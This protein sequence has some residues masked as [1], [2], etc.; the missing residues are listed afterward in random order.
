MTVKQ[1]IQKNHAEAERQDIKD[2]NAAE[3]FFFGNKAHPAEHHSNRYKQHRQKQLPLE[4]QLAGIQNKMQNNAD[5]Q[6]NTERY[7]LDK[8]GKRVIAFCRQQ[9]GQH[10]RHEGGEHVIADNQGDADNHGETQHA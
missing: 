3:I 9:T 6:H 7:V 10:E 8:Y 5:N 2:G 1:H 4:L